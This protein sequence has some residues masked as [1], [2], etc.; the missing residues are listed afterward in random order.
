MKKLYVALFA[1]ILFALGTAVYAA[2]AGPD[3]AASPDG[4][5]QG[6]AWH[7]HS[8]RGKLDLSKEQKDRMRE[9]WNRYR[10]D[11]HDLRYDLMEKRVEVK[12][13]F[14]DPKTDQATLLSR[15]NELNGLREKLMERR[16]QAKLEWRSIL[17]PEQ[18]QKL[19]R[20]PG[21]HAMSRGREMM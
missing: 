10:T 17:T 21:G 4:G 7:H 1:L 15:E 20:M 9:V 16:T 2:P 8:I 13:L 18:I 3:A 5:S 12:K 19:D 6:R 14:T 11:V